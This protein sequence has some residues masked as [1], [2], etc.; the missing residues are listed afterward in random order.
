MERKRPAGV[1]DGMT[2]SE[3]HGELLTT[4]LGIIVSVIL[5]SDL[6]CNTE[7]QPRGN[8]GV[9]VKEVCFCG[10]YEGDSLIVCS[11]LPVLPNNNIGRTGGWFW[12]VRGS[13]PK[14][15]YGDSAMCD[16]KPVQGPVKGD[17]GGFGAV[18]LAVGYESDSDSECE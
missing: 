16:M 7:K 13:S 2:E 1:N 17:D 3:S 18:F 5:G 12:P 10:A 15:S 9:G 6:G 4:K 8:V 14:L 11:Y